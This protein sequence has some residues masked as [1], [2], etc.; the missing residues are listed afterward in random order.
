MFCSDQRFKKMGK[1]IFTYENH[2]ASN[3][4]AVLALGPP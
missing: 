3:A 2:K 4:N 1:K